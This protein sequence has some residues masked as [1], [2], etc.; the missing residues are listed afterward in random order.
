M[1]GQHS[2]DLPATEE[3]ICKTQQSMLVNFGSWLTSPS[4]SRS[5]GFCSSFFFLPRVVSSK[6]ASNAL[7]TSCSSW[8]TPDTVW[9]EVAALD[10]VLPPSCKERAIARCR[11]SSGF[12]SSVRSTTLC[13]SSCGPTGAAGGERTTAGG[14]GAI[15]AVGDCDPERRLK[16]LSIEYQETLEQYLR[17]SQLP[18]LGYS[19]HLHPSSCPGPCGSGR[20]RL[21]R[22]PSWKSKNRSSSG[23]AALV[24]SRT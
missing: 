15:P 17:A 20:P 22:S 2:S 4:L 5:C 1:S 18:L 23:K 14:R 9:E 3:G 12:V 10:V 11:S 13:F 8:L 21:C 24:T 16:Y 6:L 7:L 19:L